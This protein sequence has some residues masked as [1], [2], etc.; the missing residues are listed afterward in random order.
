[1]VWARLERE[2]GAALCVATLH[3]SAHRS[4]RAA[5][6]VERAARQAIEW[7]GRHPLVFG[8][9]FNVRPSEQPWVFERLQ[10]EHGFSAPTG[11]GLID[12]LLARRLA[13]REPPR[14]LAPGVRELRD[15]AGMVVRLSDHAPVAAVF[16]EVE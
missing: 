13:V 14:Q 2:D 8:G 1:M 3:A 10:L 12:H 7:S 4:R 15:A 11:P 9:D 5:A 16:E 6:E